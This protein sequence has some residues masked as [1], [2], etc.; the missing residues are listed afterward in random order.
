MSG[1]IFGNIFRAATFGESHGPAT[2]CVIDGCPAGLALSA[3]D[4]EKELARRRPGAGR[5]GTTSRKESDTPEILSGVYEGKT[6]GTP[7]AIVI[8]NADHHS[9]DYDKLKDVYRPGH[10]DWAWEAKY[11]VRDHRGG[12]RSS[13]RET[14]CRVAA[15]AVAKAFLTTMGISVAARIAEGPEDEQ[16]AALAE[17]GDSA[18]GVISCVISGL[19]AGLGEPVFGKITSRLGEAV[20]SIGAC[21]GIEFGEGFNAAKL[22]GSQNNDEILAPPG[23]VTS[24]AVAGNAAFRTNR[25]GGSLGGISTGQDLTFRAAF[26]PAASIRLNQKTVNRSGEKADLSV[27][28]R[29]D[30]CIL[31]RALPVVEAMA[32]LVIADLVLQQRCARV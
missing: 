6:L 9:A 32:A 5:P 11:G 29:H 19:P 27:E 15:G 13:G 7:I 14:A 2:G 17:E 30:A 18:G 3:A 31:T 23:A 16:L 10:A 20:L 1:N 12:G 4:I 26:K 22:R 28:G 8:R 21:K 24:G 25:A